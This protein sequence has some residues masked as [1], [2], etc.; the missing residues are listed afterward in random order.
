MQPGQRMTDLIE[1]GCWVEI[2]RIVLQPQERAPQ[3]PADTREVPLEMRVRGFLARAASPGSE[4]EIIT[5]T[6]RRLRGVLLAVN[7]AYNHSFGAPIA[8]LLGI[9]GEVRAFLHNPDRC[10]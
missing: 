7:P 1:Q 9:G 10:P 2:Q 4:A 5:V 6:G 3:V 8:E